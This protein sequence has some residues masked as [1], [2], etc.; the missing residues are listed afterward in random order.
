MWDVL[1]SQQK[2]IFLC[3]IEVARPPLTDQEHLS[4]SFF[5]VFEFC[6]CVVDD[7]GFP[8]SRSCMINLVQ[9]A[10][11]E[12]GTRKKQAEKNDPDVMELQTR[13]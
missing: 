9:C 6:V 1:C 3:G 4:E 7:W 10:E 13:L 12:S 11:E 5:V 2:R 8:E